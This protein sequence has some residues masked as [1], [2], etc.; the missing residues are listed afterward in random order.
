[1]DKLK[2]L[3]TSN[4]KEIYEMLAD[5]RA[6]LGDIREAIQYSKAMSDAYMKA[7]EENKK[8]N[9]PAWLVQLMYHEAELQREMMARIVE[10]VERNGTHGGLFE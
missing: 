7:Y 3:L 9:T 6:G 5:G 2:N 8:N 4:E 1:M 10:E